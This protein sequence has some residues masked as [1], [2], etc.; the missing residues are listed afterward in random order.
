MGF[1]LLFIFLACDQIYKTVLISRYFYRKLL[2]FGCL[3]PDL[4]PSQTVE[5]ILNAA[6]KRETSNSVAPN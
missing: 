2:W 5:I 3:N 4:H 6:D 1:I